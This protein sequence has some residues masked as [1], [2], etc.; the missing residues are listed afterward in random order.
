[1]NL[2]TLTDTKLAAF[3]RQA[4]NEI[5]R[6]AKAATNGYDAASIIHGNEMAK[7]AL[8]FGRRWESLDPLH[9]PAE[10]RQDHAP[11]CRLGTGAREYI[12]GPPLSLWLS[13]RSASGLRMPLHSDR[14]AS[15]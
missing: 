7:R 3:H 12:R 6:R 14:A 10:L 2:L 11:G 13:Q 1:M 9:R 8:L 4:I 5:A 15:S